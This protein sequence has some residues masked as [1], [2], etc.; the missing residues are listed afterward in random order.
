MHPQEKA[1][2][3][4]PPDPPGTSRH[5]HK[6]PPPPG[7]IAFS[8]CTDGSAMIFPVGWKKPTRIEII[9]FFTCSCQILFYDENLPRI[10]L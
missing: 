5:L 8:H 1:K 10:I 7:P 2:G 4:N 3:G 6:S 9:D